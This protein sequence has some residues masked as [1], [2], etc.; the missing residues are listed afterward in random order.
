[1]SFSTSSQLIENI[2]LRLPRYHNIVARPD[3]DNSFLLITIK[4]VLR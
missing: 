3:P 4:T 1:M 2:D